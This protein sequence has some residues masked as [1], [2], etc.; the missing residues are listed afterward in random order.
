[1]QPDQA[2]KPAK[3]SVTITPAS[4]NRVNEPAS[5]RVA[6][7]VNEPASARV[8]NR[9]NQPTPAGAYA[10]AGGV[11]ML[12][13][14]RPMRRERRRGPINPVYIV[15]ITVVPLAMLATMVWAA[16]VLFAAPNQNQPAAMIR[17]TPAA[18]DA[19]QIALTYQQDA[20][21]QRREG[22]QV[23]ISG[24][25]KNNSNMTINNVFLKAFL[26][27]KGANGGAELAGSGVGNSGGPLAPGA[28]APFTV[29]AQLAAG[30]G[31][32]IGTP[33]PAPQDFETVQVLVDQ[34][35]IPTPAAT[36]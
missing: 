28:T 34:V 17:I 35:W 21:A 29:T 24:T 20:A 23:Y 12:P 25:A 15:L 26:Y 13:T 7:R 2:P 11:P 5:A 4:A 18:A 33:T 36:P 6:N 1:M 22:D 19:S 14:S 31:V 30:P 3:D 8:A 16:A 27:R 9:S 10:P 32:K